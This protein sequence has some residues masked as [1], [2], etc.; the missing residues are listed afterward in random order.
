M[1]KKLSH[2]IC[3][4]CFRPRLLLL[5]VLVCLYSCSNNK[6]R[7][8]MGKWHSV[9]VENRDKDNF[10][11]SSK[12]FID[13]MGLNNTDETNLF[14]YGVTNIDSLRR[15]LRVQFDSAYA[16]QISIDTHSIF[17][18]RAD[19]T[20]LFSFP[21]KTEKGTWYIDK[22]GKLILDETNELGQTEHLRIDIALLNEQ[23]LQ[24]TFIRQLEE[25]LADTSVVT[26]R[27]EK[28]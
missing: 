27:R 14:I 9:R 10:F 16:A 28:N 11:R 3:F 6:S 19:S 8:I 15:E 23:H 24:L 22:E 25:G 1:G 12:Q 2:F 26:F 21:G 20:V 18:F 13:T 7:L 4:A 5:L 17:E